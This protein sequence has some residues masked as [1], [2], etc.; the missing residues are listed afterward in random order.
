MPLPTGTISMSQVNTEL[1]RSS[2]ATISLGETAVRTLAGVAS[3]T[4][5]M[6]NLRGKS[7]ETISI[8]DHSITGYG[9][10]SAGAWYRLLSNGQAQ[11]ATDYNGVATYFL[12][13]WVTPTSAAANYEVLVTVVSGSLA[14][15]SAT[16]GSWISLNTNRAWFVQRTGN[17]YTSAQITV[18]IRR[19]GTSTVLDT[20]TIYLE[21]EVSD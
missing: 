2:T 20:A 21:A 11:A 17:G 4:I 10:S 6:D 16:T 5:S 9:L 18:Q 1:G 14:F 7:A 12:E 13:N 19:V 15:T 3:G 8:S